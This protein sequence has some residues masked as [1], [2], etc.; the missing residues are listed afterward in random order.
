[1]T[2]Q[3]LLDLRLRSISKHQEIRKAMAKLEAE[4]I[5]ENSPYKVGDKFLLSTKIVKNKTVEE[6]G[7]VGEVAV[8]YDLHTLPC[9]RVVVNDAGGRYVKTVREVI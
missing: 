8:D 1:M 2:A 7:A 5:Q 9:I 3:E 6:W 4:F